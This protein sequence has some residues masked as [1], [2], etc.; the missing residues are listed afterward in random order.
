MMGELLQ[1][2][3]MD[4]MAECQH[5]EKAA[6]PP[7]VQTREL[8][9]EWTPLHHRPHRRRD[10]LRLTAAC[11]DG[12]HRRRQHLNPSRVIPLFWPK[13]WI[14]WNEHGFDPAAIFVPVRRRS[15]LPDC[16]C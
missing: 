9:G 13:Q 1:H 16:L 10:R 14:R 5:L 3:R 15:G 4:S 11:L 6:M 2:Q 7:T 8:P 12:L